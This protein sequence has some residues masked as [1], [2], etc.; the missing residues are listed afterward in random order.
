V[1]DK[2][3]FETDLN[4]GEC[5]DIAVKRELSAMMMPLPESLTAGL[6]SVSSTQRLPGRTEGDVAHSQSLLPEK[7]EVVGSYSVSN[8]QK[9]TTSTSSSTG[10]HFGNPPVTGVQ[11]TSVSIQRFSSE[12]ARSEPHSG[13]YSVASSRQSGHQIA[14][15]PGR[16]VGSW[17]DP[18]LGSDAVKNE[19]LPDDYQH[20]QTV[21]SRRENTDGSQQ[22]GERRQLAPYSPSLSM[23]VILFTFWHSL[24]II[25]GLKFV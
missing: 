14:L 18:R 3:Y 12:V 10:T 2:T 15:E 23:Q 16:G 22:Y 11:V 17:T 6:Q 7:S 21:N 8:A 1:P 5:R 4:T 25:L 9:V 13:I 20:R 24:S 19:G